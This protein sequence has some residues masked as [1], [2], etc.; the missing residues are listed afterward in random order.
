MCIFPTQQINRNDQDEQQKERERSMVSCNEINLLAF[1]RHGLTASELPASSEGPRSSL[2]RP[3][4]H[5]SF[6]SVT[7]RLM[8]TS[9]NFPERVRPSP[10]V[11]IHTVFMCHGAGWPGRSL[12]CGAA[13]PGAGIATRLC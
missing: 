3:S 5:L 7:L 9:A 6:C 13:S 10:L 8:L 12:Y 11:F 4:P 1:V 2:I